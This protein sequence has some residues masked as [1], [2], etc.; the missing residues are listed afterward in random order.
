MSRSRLELICRVSELS[1]EMRSRSSLLLLI[2]AS[3][4]TG[5]EIG[6]GNFVTEIVFL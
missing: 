2:N 4:S 3:E 6:S 5:D 1:L